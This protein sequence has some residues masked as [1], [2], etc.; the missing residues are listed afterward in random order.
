M[1]QYL[2]HDIENNERN[3][4]I[5]YDLNQF[6]VKE[7]LNEFICICFIIVLGVTSY[8]ILFIHLIEE[9]DGSLL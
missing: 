5:V 3:E 4:K 8:V 6:K 1:N 7:C 2:I 9:E